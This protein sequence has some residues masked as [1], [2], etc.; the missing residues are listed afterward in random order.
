LWIGIDY[1][2]MRCAFYGFIYSWSK[3]I[4]EETGINISI[5][6]ESYGSRRYTQ[7]LY[8]CLTFTFW[9]KTYK[10]DLILYSSVI[11]L[12]L[13]F[14]IQCLSEDT[15]C[16]EFSALAMSNMA[17][18]FSSKAAIFEHGGLEPLVRCLSSVDPDVQKNS[19]EAI[20]L[21]LMVNLS[22]I[23][24][25]ECFKSMKCFKWRFPAKYLST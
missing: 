1:A 7:S 6:C 2:H 18:E 5:P 9:T 10:S 21:L 4:S 8:I 22:Y 19:I 13:Q 16:H 15:V 17:T 14:F 12:W 20:A 11:I 3:K 25:G 24:V 23:L